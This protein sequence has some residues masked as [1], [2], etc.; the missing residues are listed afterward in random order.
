MAD[1]VQ[2]RAVTDVFHIFDS[3][4]DFIALIFRLLSTE[5]S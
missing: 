3:A 5:R 2:I 4:S 1:L